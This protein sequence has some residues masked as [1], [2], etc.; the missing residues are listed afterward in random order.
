M[1]TNSLGGVDGDWVSIQLPVKIQL[2]SDELLA[3]WVHHETSGGRVGAWKRG[4]N[5]LGSDWNVA[6]CDVW[7]QSCNSFPM[8]SAKYH[9]YI[10]LVMEKINGADGYLNFHEL[11][12]YGIP[13]Y[14]PDAHGTDVIARSVPNVPNTDWLEVYYDGQ[15]YTSMPSTITDKSGNSVT[16]TPSGV[17]FDSTWKAFSFDGSND[18]ISGNI[19]F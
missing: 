12:L 3:T 10:A 18:T 8:E 13:E 2:H 5:E 15:D 11:E 6:Q 17:T 19:G 1:G 9:N 7:R 14:D 4:R 16:G